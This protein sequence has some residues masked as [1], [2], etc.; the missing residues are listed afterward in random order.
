MQM[1]VGSTRWLWEFLGIAWSNENDAN[2]P[3]G[4]TKPPGG[5]THEVCCLAA[6]GLSP[7]GG[8]VSPS[9]RFVSFL[10][11]QGLHFA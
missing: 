5:I 6:H 11:D 1:A 3:E 10:F 8:L 7:P 2:P 9:G 4:D